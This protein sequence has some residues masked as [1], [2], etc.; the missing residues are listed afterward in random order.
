MAIPNNLSEYFSAA[1]GGKLAN[2][3]GAIFGNGEEGNN[4]KA[5]LAIYLYADDNK[6][7]DPHNTGQFDPDSIRLRDASLSAPGLVTL[8]NGQVQNVTWRDSV[9]G[10]DL[11]R[12]LVEKLNETPR[13]Q[14]NFINNVREN[15]GDRAA[16]DVQTYFSST[17]DFVNAGGDAQKKQAAINATQASL[18][19]LV[20]EIKS[21]VDTAHNAPGMYTQGIM[22]NPDDDF[23][24][25]FGPTARANRDIDRYAATR[26]AQNAGFPDNDAFNRFE[27]AARGKVGYDHGAFMTQLL[28]PENADKLQT[29]LGL[30]SQSGPEVSLDI[31]QA[32]QDIQNAQATVNRGEFN[33]AVATLAHA[34]FTALVGGFAW[35]DRVEHGDPNEAKALGIAGFGAPPVAPSPPLPAASPTVPSLN[36]FN[37][38]DDPAPA[39]P[40]A[41]A[42]QNQS[43]TPPPP[44]PAQAAAAQITHISSGLIKGGQDVTHA[45]APASVVPRPRMPEVLSI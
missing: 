14:L 4:I 40:Q 41:P 26:A 3:I 28:R 12:V 1:V 20:A 2:G 36:N 13:D 33:N 18:N 43:Y 38:G 21:A 44:S 16:Q 35:N 29:A 8:Q 37:L 30:I 32:A 34:Q 42:V 22:G 17:V 39:T 24:K 10:H 31:K 19:G 11:N 7:R 27:G 6:N 5:D 25:M 23:A 45:A 9:V 15:L